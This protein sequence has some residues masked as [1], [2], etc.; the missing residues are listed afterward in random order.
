MIHKNQSIK[1]LPSRQPVQ[2]GRAK[3]IQS[4]IKNPEQGTAIADFL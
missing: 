2:K 4:R 3:A 1:E